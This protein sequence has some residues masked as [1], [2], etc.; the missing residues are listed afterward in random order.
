MLRPTSRLPCREETGRV[1][2][3]LHSELPCEERCLK[4]VPD[5]IPHRFPAIPAAWRSIVPQRVRGL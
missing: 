3:G 1:D 4:C 2:S 5:E